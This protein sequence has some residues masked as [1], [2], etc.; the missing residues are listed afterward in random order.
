ML[1]ALEEMRNWRAAYEL[2][3]PQS[4]GD[5][6]EEEAEE[7]E[8]AAGPPIGFDVILEWM[9]GKM[10]VFEE[11]SA[12]VPIRP[13]AR[14]SSATS[15]AASS[16]PTSPCNPATAVPAP[17]AHARTHALLAHRK[18]LPAHRLVS[19]PPR[20]TWQANE[21]LGSPPSVSSPVSPAKTRMVSASFCPHDAREAFAEC[22]PIKAT[23]LKKGGGGGGSRSSGGGDGGGCSSARVRA[24]W[25][26]PPVPSHEV[27]DPY[28]TVAVP[29][30]RGL[31]QLTEWLVCC[32][33][34]KY[35]GVRPAGA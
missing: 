15:S 25:A 14:S 35:S 10:W 3:E 26:Q 32:A 29:Q 22:L 27:T 28:A 19:M 2:D 16:P 24:S 7:E 11:A 5:G 6:Q 31:A 1:E 21:E 17:T 12:M 33:E 9:E 8:E 20:D 13:R 23:I 34:R 18:L 30:L 4:G